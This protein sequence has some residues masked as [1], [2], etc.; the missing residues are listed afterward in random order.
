MVKSVVSNDQAFSD[1][2]FVHPSDLEKLAAAADI[3]LK[4]ATERGVLCSINDGVVVVV[5]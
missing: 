1:L 4:V 3:E 5:K 2:A